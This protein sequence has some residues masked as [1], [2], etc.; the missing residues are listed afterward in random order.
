[1]KEVQEN[2]SFYE[3][4]EV[5]IYLHL[6]NHLLENKEIVKQLPISVKRL[7]NQFKDIVVT[8]S[9]DLKRMNIL[10]HRIHLVYPFLIIT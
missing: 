7:L 8:H 4:E 9:N 10:K 6:A 5:N 2:I 1:M 3:D